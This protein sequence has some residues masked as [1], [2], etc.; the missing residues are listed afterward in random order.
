[1]CLLHN[2]TN[3]YPFHSANVNNK[4]R[5]VSGKLD[6]WMVGDSERIFLCNI[7]FNKSSSMKKLFCWHQSG[8]LLFQRKKNK[9]NTGQ[10]PLS[11]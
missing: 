10:L 7:S 9:K 5:N 6:N 3:C 8:L 4:I 11:Q 2:M 1:M